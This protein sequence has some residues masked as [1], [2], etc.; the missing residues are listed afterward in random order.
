MLLKEILNATSAEHV[1]IGGVSFKLTKE[2][3]IGKY[4]N[5]KYEMKDGEIEDL[6]D[7]F[8]LTHP[9]C[10]WASEFMSNMVGSRKIYDKYFKDL[11]TKLKS[12]TLFRGMVFSNRSPIIK[13]LEQ[14]KQINIP[15]KGYESWSLSKQ[16]DLKNWTGIVLFIPTQRAEVLFDISEIGDGLGE[17]IVKN[18]SLIDFEIGHVDIIDE[19]Y[20]QKIIYLNPK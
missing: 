16:E 3:Q 20:K 19:Q 18:R 13:Q 8:E 10:Y 15:F 4:L 5:N 12:E 2:M 9:L 11:S 7:E 6:Y 14:T 17:V 1:N